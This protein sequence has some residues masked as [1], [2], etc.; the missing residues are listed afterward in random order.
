MDDFDT[1]EEVN[2]LFFYLPEE[3]SGDAEKFGDEPARDT[4]RIIPNRG[5]ED[6][7]TKCTTYITQKLVKPSQEFPLTKRSK[8]KQCL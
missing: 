3:A 8:L 6:M 7:K 4:K 5:G 2:T 1:R